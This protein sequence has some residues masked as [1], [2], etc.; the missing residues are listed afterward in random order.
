MQHFFQTT[1]PL[2]CIVRTLSVSFL[3]LFF[4][5]FFSSSYLFAGD[6]WEI[7]NFGENWYLK[8]LQ[9]Q[10]ELLLLQ[11]LWVCN[12]LFLSCSR[13]LNWIISLLSIVSQINTTH[14]DI[15]LFIWI[16]W[17]VTKRHSPF[18]YILNIWMNIVKIKFDLNVWMY[19][20]CIK[21][22]ECFFLIDK[23]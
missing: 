5:V 14:Q 8:K 12:Q 15:Y 18:F 19:R 1:P 9:L 4:F 3:F 16:R 13:S 17:G 6:C 10:R 21:W 20:G 22:G 23:C 7:A 2:C 11:P